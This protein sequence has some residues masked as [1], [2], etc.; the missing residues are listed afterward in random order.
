M[1]VIFVVMVAML[2]LGCTK[3]KVNTD[4]A[5]DVSSTTTQVESKPAAKFPKQTREQAT[6]SC[7]KVK[8]ES[9]QAEV[10]GCVEYVMKNM[11]Q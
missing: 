3:Q 9:T 5:S 6:E 8:P 1:K 10:D 11:E 4:V 7:K 2:F